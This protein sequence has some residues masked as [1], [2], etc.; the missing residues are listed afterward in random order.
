[1][2][3]ESPNKQTELLSDPAL[4]HLLT[5]ELAYRPVPHDKVDEQ[6]LPVWQVRF[7]LTSDKQQEFGLS[8]N[9]EIHLGRGKNE[10]DLI[11][12]TPYGAEKSGVSRRHV[13]LR[14]TPTNLFVVDLGSTNGTRRNGRSI[15][16]NTPYALADGDTLSLGNL[17][18]AVQIV[19]RP[20]LRTAPLKTRPDLVEA[21]S[22]I[23]KAIT[24]Q[25][26]L[27]EV[28]NQ[29]VTTA[30][31]L[32]SAGETSIWLVDEATGELFLE[33]RRGMD[34]A[35]LRRTRMPIDADTPA[36]RVI[37]TGKPLR[38][39]SEPGEASQQ[40]MTGYLVEALA[41]VPVSLGGITFGVLAS[42]HQEPGKSFDDQDERLLSAIADYAAIAIQNARLYRATDK[43]LS[44][45]VRELA[46]L[47]ELSR[48]VSASLNMEEVYKVLVEQVKRHMPVADLH[49]YL[50]DERN[51][52][53]RPFGDTSELPIYPLGRGILGQVVSQG[54][55]II[56]NNISNYPGF[57]E[58]LDLITSQANVP[59][60]AVPL[61]VQGEVVGVLVLHSQ[62]GSLFS[63]EDAA[64]LRSFALPVA[65]AVENARLYANVERQR[66][67]IMAMGNTLSEPLTILDDVGRILVSNDAAQRLLKANMSQFFEA[68]S[69]SVGRTVEVKI[70]DETYLSTTE[71]VDGIGTIAMMQDIT[72]VKQLEEDRSE[73]M[74]MLSHDLKNPLMAVT[75]YANLLERTEPLGDKGKRF[76]SEINV[77]AD[78]MLDM[79]THLL[80]TVDQE[81]AIQL[82]QELVDLEDVTAQVLRDTEGVALSKTIEVT[83][84]TNGTPYTISGDGLRLYH[85]LLNLVDN[86]IKYSPEATQVMVTTTY[87]DASVVVQVADQGPGIPEKDLP[88][89]FDKFFR[90]IQEGLSAK[91][92]G[93]GLSAV[94]GIVTAHRGTIQV[95][96]LPGQGA[97]FTV[98]LPTQPPPEA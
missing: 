83:A 97:C 46:A 92:S 37:K 82:S 58:Q 15:G 43:A 94:K 78:R 93:V 96:N 52:I 2:S 60:A 25:L 90:G 26:N 16:H 22:Q 53:L 5:G 63:E 80:D 35:R 29:V 85:M 73:F 31:S 81:D 9:G 47:N 79:I 20:Y 17:E 45:R 8:I 95:E 19:K 70:G 3:Q 36:G 59:V 51:P 91:G 89:V 61:K 50:R 72:Y 24:T 10:K 7:L 13:A 41:Y 42:A 40:I 33:A 39:S 56:T 54:E 44:Q 84:V 57:D 75:G 86:A 55:S 62:P 38:T 67:A 66:G 6:Q 74:H 21:L 71:H 4:D 12:L 30:M 76:L 48:T 34:D 27:D 77:A 32:T 14:P 68:I 87:S 64:L 23:G 1:M 88:H 49:I 69:S 28:L 18:L 65:T 98:E 11:D